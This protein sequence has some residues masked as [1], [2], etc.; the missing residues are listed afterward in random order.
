MPTGIEQ[1]RPSETDQ[2]YKMTRA[3][4][5]SMS[6]A[7]ASGEGRAVSDGGTDEQLSQHG[8]SATQ[9]RALLDMLF[10]CSV[11]DVARVEEICKTWRIDVS[12]AKS[13]DYDKRYPIHL[14][15]SEGC[16]SVVDWLIKNKAD[17]NVI[18][19]FKHTPLED[20]VRGD[21]IEVAKL[22]SN[23]GGMVMYQGKL[24]NLDHSQFAGYVKM[25][26]EGSFENELEW[27]VDPSNINIGTVIGRGE[28]GTVYSARW[29][30]TL[31]AVKVLK[32]TSKLAVEELKSELNA[33]RKAHHPHTMQ[34][35]G[36]CTKQTPYMLVTELMSGGSLQDAFQLM[37]FQLP[38]RRGLEIALD[39]ARG[40]NYLHTRKPSPIIHRDLKPGNFMIGGSVYSSKS[41]L[42]QNTG[43]VKIADFGLSK[44]LPTSLA[45]HDDQYKMT[46]ETGTYRYMAPEVF[47]HE[48]YNR[49]VD[50]YSFA[51][52]CY[53]L[54]SGIPPM[55]DQH[56]AR[57]AQLAAL[58]SK[59]PMWPA[60]SRWG[61]KIPDALKELVE[62]CWAADPEDRPSF[63]DICVE[64]EGIVKKLPND[65]PET[66]ASCQCAIQ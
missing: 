32:S 2:L 1:R 64:L 57:A 66:A 52:I 14:A 25:Y 10:F 37:N 3:M 65:V 46:G 16:F 40:M 62:K 26:T 20:A 4:N 38:L 18:D 19:R 47:R 8:S 6:E 35:L 58:H 27:E 44:T 17:V 39:A 55:H 31:V 63:I 23:A 45:N 33:L 28:F 15:A 36:A 41:S 34:F 43:V 42:V 11:G 7:G 50:V 9:R 49:K 24:V 53:Y 21:H 54:F 30:N 13:C 51:M 59:R 48:P 60:Q 5:S 22:L 56:A 29:H 61:T 12:D